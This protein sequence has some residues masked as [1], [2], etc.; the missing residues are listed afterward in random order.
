M[1]PSHLERGF[2]T[3][4]TCGTLAATAAA[5]KLFAL[6]PEETANALG[7]AGIQAAGLLEVTIDGQVAKPLHARKAAQAGVLAALTQGMA[8]G[9]PGASSKGEKGFLP[10]PW[11]M[12]GNLNHCAGL[13]QHLHIDNSYKLI[14]PAATTR[15]PVDHLSLER[16]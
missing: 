16:I 1:N 8:P 15:P 5:A 3:T 12:H 9:G 14:L 2:H 4:G 10:K 6:N 11:P 7:L 13:G